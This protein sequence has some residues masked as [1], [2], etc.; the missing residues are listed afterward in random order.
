MMD[1]A[2]RLRTLERMARQRAVS[3]NYRTLTQLS[4]LP[5][6]PSPEVVDDSPAGDSL[7]AFRAWSQSVEANGCGAVSKR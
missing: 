1:L 3:V 5:N 6:Q 7:P 2:G 4:Y